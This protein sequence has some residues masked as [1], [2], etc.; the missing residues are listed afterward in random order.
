MID[1]F[2]FAKPIAGY[3]R[4]SVNRD[5]RVFSDCNDG[6]FVE[7]TPSKSTNG[8]LRVFLYKC[9]KRKMFYIHRLVANAFLK[10]PFNLP[11]VNHKDFN[12]ENNT[13]ENLEVCSFRYNMIYNSMFGK[14]HS[15]MFVGVTWNKRK[16]KWLAQ[17]QVGKKKIFLGYYDTQEKAH[18]AYTNALNSDKNA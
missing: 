9:G 2:S 14:R 7:L 18:D 8:Y 1:L 11:C 5:G 12:K 15:S 16:K 4:Y 17:Y 6:K 13:V 10:N 3:E